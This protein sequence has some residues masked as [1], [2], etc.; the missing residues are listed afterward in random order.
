MKR[1]VAILALASLA[2]V[3][4]RAEDKTPVPTPKLT[5]TT[6]ALNA[7]ALKKATDALAIAQQELAQAKA[8]PP[9]TP[10]APPCSVA[11][12]PDSW[13]GSVSKDQVFKLLSLVQ[14]VPMKTTDRAVT[15]EM[16]FAGIFSD[17]DT[18]CKANAQK[19][20]K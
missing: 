15:T 11:T 17:V 10:P 20:T 16:A 6:A 12:V 4:A 19:P 9:P 5:A 18:W 1:F 3:S 13:R 2:S 7:D 14:D 8:P